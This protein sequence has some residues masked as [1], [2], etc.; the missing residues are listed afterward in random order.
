MASRAV[1]ATGSTVATVAGC[2]M[3]P[4]D[5]VGR[6]HVVA[7]VWRMADRQSLALLRR[8][9][10]RREASIS[11]LLT[12]SVGFHHVIRAWAAPTC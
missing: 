6:D 1:S 11:W 12:G 9:R 2:A 5:I 7:R 8:F 4:R 10:E 3:D